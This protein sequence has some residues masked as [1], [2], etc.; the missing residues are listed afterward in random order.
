[1]PVRARVRSHSGLLFW[2][3]LFK[4]V[5]LYV[6]PLCRHG[7]SIY[8]PCITALNSHLQS[9]STSAASYTSECLPWSS[10][11]SF[12]GRAPKLSVYRLE[13]LPK[14]PT[15]VTEY[16]L[17]QKKICPPLLKK[18]NLAHDAFQNHRGKARARAS[19]AALIW[20]RRSGVYSLVGVAN[21]G[22]E[23]P[24]APET[25]PPVPHAP[26][27][28]HLLVIILAPDNPFKNSKSGF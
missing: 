26:C 10:P 20:T 1:M 4:P 9:A 11:S 3:S 14:W 12:Q 16:T 25:G 24:G 28:S 15:D 17:K 23:L 7:R 22:L 2:R 5:F 13:L 27:C 6:L 19:G 21:G 18:L 8:I